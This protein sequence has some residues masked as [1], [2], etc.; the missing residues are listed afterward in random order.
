MNQGKLK[1]ALIGGVALGVASQIPLLNLANC[2]CCALVIGGGVLAAYF[3]LKD[4]P[5]APSPPYGDGM[6]VGALAGI[7]G[8]FVSTIVSIPMTLLFSG[9]GMWQ[10]ISESL[11]EIEDMPPEVVEMIAGMGAGGFAIGAIIFSLMLGLVINAI[12]AGLGG[13]LGVAIFGKKSTPPAA[14][15]APPPPPAV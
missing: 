13:L 15:Q 2:A 10:A 4:A 8:A 11:S 5:P 14:P 6:L 3:Y 1:P 12:F 9:A 7:I